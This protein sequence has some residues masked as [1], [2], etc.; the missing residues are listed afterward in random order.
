MGAAT[1]IQV[2]IG[3]IAAVRAEG[4]L[5]TLLG[6]CVGMVLQD[7]TNRVAVLAHVVRPAGQG[8]GMGPGYFADQAAPRARDLAIQNGANPHELMVRIAGGGRM[9]SGQADIG[10]RNADAIKEE[11]YRLGMVFGGHLEGPTDGGCFLCVDVANGKVSVKRLV[12][13]LDDSAWQRLRHDLG[14]R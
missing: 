9:L 2:P 11:T 8:A 6:S 14:K 10:A 12:G 3:G 13:A 4:V 7:L 1:V 5:T